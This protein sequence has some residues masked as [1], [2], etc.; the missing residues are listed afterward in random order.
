MFE[1]PTPPTNNEMP[2]DGSQYQGEQAKDVSQRPEDLGLGDCRELLVRVLVAKPGKHF[3]LERLNV[4]E[5][6]SLHRKSV[7]AV[8]TEHLLC[9]GHRDVNLLVPTDTESRADLLEDA[10][11]AEADP[12]DRDL[13]P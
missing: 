8:N 4:I 10:D 6:G 13:T 5:R 2:R 7:D 3:A 11:D 9:R 12:G 1:T